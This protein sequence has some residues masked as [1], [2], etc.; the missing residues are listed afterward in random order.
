MF[1]T[2]GTKFPFL[3]QLKLQLGRASAVFHEMVVM[4]QDNIVQCS[5][6]DSNS[7]ISN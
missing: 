1:D 6:Y 7:M 3:L 2:I 5:I 4:H